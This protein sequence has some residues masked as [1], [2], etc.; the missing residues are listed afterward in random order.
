MVIKLMSFIEALL[1]QL[2]LD[3]QYQI[4]IDFMIK[5]LK[6]IQSLVI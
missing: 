2:K 6:K 3:K 4:N 5:S 1:S